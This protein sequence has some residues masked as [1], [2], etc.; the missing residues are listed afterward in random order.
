MKNASKAQNTPFPE[1]NIFITCM[2]GFADRVPD[3]RYWIS[4]GGTSN[5]CTAAFVPCRSRTCVA[6]PTQ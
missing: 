4:E 2:L 1:A 6:M 3:C 5:P